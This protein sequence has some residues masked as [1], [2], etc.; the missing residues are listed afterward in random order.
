MSGLA[1]WQADFRLWLEHGDE[2]AA[3]RLAPDSSAGLAVYQNNYRAQLIGCLADAFPQTVAWV[4]DA[5]FESA[6]AH[7]SDAHPPSSWSLDHYPVGFPAMLAALHPDDP[8]IAELALLEWQLGEIFIGPDA[9]VLTL[10]MLPDADWERAVL[11]LAPGARLLALSTN[12]AAIWAALDAGEEPHS[13]QSLPEKEVFLLWRRDFTASF[14]QLDADEAE[15]LAS[16]AEG[17]AF[18][19]LCAMLVDRQGE[20]AGLHRAGELLARWAAE[21]CLASP[22]ES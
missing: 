8:E 7:H 10:D 22:M 5:A 19:D 18:A 21:E 17:R 16:L 13:A 11:T 6:A 2:A 3:A 9:P 4:G 20:E 12:A 14:R 15:L 1:V